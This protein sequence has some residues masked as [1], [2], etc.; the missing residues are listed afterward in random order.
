MNKKVL[1]IEI[2]ILIVIIFIGIYVSYQ[3]SDLDCSTIDNADTKIECYKNLL[4]EKRDVSVCQDINNS[5]IKNVCYSNFA[6]ITKDYSICE[7]HVVEKNVV[8]KEKDSCYINIATSK[9]NVVFCEELLDRILVTSCYST[10]AIKENDTTYCTRLRFDTINKP[11]Y[12]LVSSENNV[13]SQ[14]IYAS[15]RDNCYYSFGDDATRHLEKDKL[16]VCEK[17]DNMDIKNNC[18]IEF[19]IRLDDKSICNNIFD[20]KI[21]D[22]CINISPTGE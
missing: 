10:F 1:T 18:Y 5:Y 15:E 19:A 17:I 7:K 16:Y 12:V 9:G 13:I 14:T 21:K 6:L 20:K 2:I 3:T 11:V 4:Q 8:S 22:S